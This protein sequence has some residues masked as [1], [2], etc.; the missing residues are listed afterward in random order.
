MLALRKIV[1][2]ILTLSQAK[3][4]VIIDDF[5][6]ITLAYSNL[7]KIR[8]GVRSWLRK[9]ESAVWYGSQAFF[10]I[11]FQVSYIF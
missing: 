9:Y 2:L 8:F 7:Q 3:V 6:G 5:C 4:R 1:I 10:S 11:F